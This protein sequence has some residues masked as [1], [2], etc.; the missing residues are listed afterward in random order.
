MDKFYLEPPKKLFKRVNNN[1]N[2]ISYIGIDGN[3]KGLGVIIEKHTYPDGA[4]IIHI[5][6][7]RKDRLPSYYDMK[8]VKNLFLGND[9]LAVHLYPPSNE[10]VNIHNYCLHLWHG[11]NEKGWKNIIS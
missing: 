10:N 2:L 3:F 9:K 8:Y 5:S 1:L 11:L 4:E 7:S 6:V